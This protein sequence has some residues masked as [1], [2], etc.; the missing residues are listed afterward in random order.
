MPPPWRMH[1]GRGPRGAA[2]ALS[3]AASAAKAAIKPAN[4]IVRARIAISSCCRPTPTLTPGASIYSDWGR[5]WTATKC[6][7]GQQLMSLCKDLRRPGARF[8][9]LTGTG[10]MQHGG[11]V[12]LRHA[13]LRGD[14]DG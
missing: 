8:T 9:A 13:R 2:L 11:H 3:S 12:R 14:I 1:Q 5:L 6:L 10:F 4:P 7:R